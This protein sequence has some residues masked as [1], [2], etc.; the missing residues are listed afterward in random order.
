MGNGHKTMDPQENLR[1]KG[2]GNL[3]RLWQLTGHEGRRK[4]GF[5]VSGMQMA[6][7]TERLRQQDLA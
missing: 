3:G 1:Q 4:P 7:L 2:F 5:R 6:L